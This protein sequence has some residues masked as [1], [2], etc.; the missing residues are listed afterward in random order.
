MDE[1]LREFVGETLDLTEE[2]AGDLVAWEAAP[3]DRASLDRIF[4][5]IHTIK[6]SSGFLDLPRIG[7]LAHAAEEYLAGCREGRTAA[8][9]AGVSAVLAA[10]ARLRDLAHALASEGAE[11]AGDDGDVLNALATAKPGEGTTAQPETALAT[12]PASTVPDSWR[13]V[14]VPLELVDALMNRV[15]DLVL[16]RNDV[17]AQLRAGSADVAALHALDRVSQ[18]LADVRTLVG[19]MRMVPLRQ[20]FAP[21]PRVVRQLADTL[22][23]RVQLHID[24]GDV[25]IDREMGEALRDPLL[26]LIRNALDHG[27]EDSATRI[28]AGKD[29]AARLSIRASAGRNRIR[30]TVADDGAGIDRTKLIDRVRRSGRFDADTLAQMS[31][32]QLDELIFTPGLSTRTEATDISGRGVGMDVVRENVER[33]GGS[34]RLDNRVGHGL[35]VT[36]E[37][38]LTLTIIGALGVRTGDSLFAIPR[39]AVAEVL[40]ASSEGVERRNAGGAGLVKVRGEI[41]PLLTVERLLGISPSSLPGDERV[42]VLVRAGGGLVAFEADDVLDHDELVLKPLPPMIAA[43]GMF[44][45]MSLP[46]S[47]RPLLLLDVEALVRRALVEPTPEEAVVSNSAPAEHDADWI[48]FIP[49]NGHLAQALPM[50]DVER[51]LRLREQSLVTVGAGCG[52]HVDGE[53]VPLAGSC[54]EILA[55]AGSEGAVSIIL[56]RDKRGRAAALAV[57]ELGAIAPLAAAISGEPEQRSVREGVAMVDGAPVEMLRAEPI[58]AAAHAAMLMEGAV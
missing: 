10:I 22:G 14:R 34:V 5:T 24:G 4:R 2:V 39:S 8:S 29:M 31:A 33:L 51:F 25:E 35:E 6:G 48:S 43:S 41:Y 56:L 46:D 30:I 54:A 53:L 38:P 17:S 1:L 20:I 16:A 45:G 36:L 28:A 32:A 42:V 12:A 50:R 3:D 37:V 11:P 19:Q 27:V 23:K 40:L 21:L 55:L 49:I 7:R 52:A 44:R 9:E 13:S 15:S 47:G 58:I 18:H 57:R 26:H